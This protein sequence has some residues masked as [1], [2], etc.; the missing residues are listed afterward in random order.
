MVLSDAYIFQ[1]FEANAAPMNF[2]LCEQYLFVPVGAK[3]VYLS[4]VIESLQEN[5]FQSCVI[6]VGTRSICQKLCMLLTYLE[7]N[8]VS[9]HSHMIQSERLTALSEFKNKRAM[10]LVVTDIASRGLD[11]PEVDLVI[12]FDIPKSV[13]TYLHRIGRTARAWR[14]GHALSLA[15]QYDIKLIHKIEAFTG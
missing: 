15:T 4:C 6:F 8:V 5:K 3:D 10:I 1:S 2:C 13:E 11:I 7:K 14:G 9:L 12:N